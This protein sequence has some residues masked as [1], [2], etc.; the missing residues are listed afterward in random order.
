MNE[1]MINHA[2]ELQKA[3]YKRLN[4]RPKTLV[5]CDLRADNLFVSKTDQNDFCIIDWQLLNS[6]SPGV[7]WVQLISSSIEPVSAYEQLEDL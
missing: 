5:H 6:T 4:S 2:D 1:L 3:F 7:E